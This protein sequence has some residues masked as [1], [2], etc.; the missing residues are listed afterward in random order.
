MTEQG[1]LFGD[2]A[3]ASRRCRGCDEMKPLSEFLLDERH[4]LGIRS[5]CKRCKSNRYSERRSD[6]SWLLRQAR[7]IA[8][9]ENLGT[10]RC[11]RCR[12]RLPLDN[13]TRQPRHSRGFSSWC[14]SCNW[15]SRRDHWV[16]RA[17]A[18]IR[19][20]CR[21]KGIPFAIEPSDLILPERCPVLGFPLEVARGQAK[22]NSPSIDRLIPALGYV[23]GN[24]D[25]ISYLA[26]TLKN[27]CTDPAQLEAVARYMRVR[28]GP[29]EFAA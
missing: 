10:L 12:R 8:V 15:E 5:L 7:L 23:R 11:S 17:L 26:N 28:L 25:V 20:E 3:V 16:A 29:K 1:S 24:V 18:N 27:N 22:Y 2:V 6:P 9:T 21:N 19:A 13:F 4:K 14:R